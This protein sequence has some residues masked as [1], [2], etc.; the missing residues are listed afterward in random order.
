VATKRFKF[1]ED[2]KIKAVDNM[3]HIVIIS[4]KDKDA[5]IVPNYIKTKESGKDLTT[6]KSK[7]YQLK[8][9]INNY[10]NYLI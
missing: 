7:K 6:T 2:C 3:L 10:W 4:N 5:F 9:N 1:T 8:K